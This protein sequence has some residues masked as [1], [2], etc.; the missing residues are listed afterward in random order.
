M[1]KGLFLKMLRTFVF[2]CH[3]GAEATAVWKLDVQYLMQKPNCIK[4]SEELT[5]QKPKT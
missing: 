2:I 5:L 3:V 1:V 4:H